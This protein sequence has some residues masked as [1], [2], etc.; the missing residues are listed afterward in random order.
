[1]TLNGTVSIITPERTLLTVETELIERF[2]SFYPCRLKQGAF[3]KGGALLLGWYGGQACD[4]TGRVFIPS[5]FSEVITRPDPSLPSVDLTEPFLSVQD[6]ISGELWYFCWTGTSWEGRTEA[7]TRCTVPVWAIQLQP[8]GDMV[9][10]QTKD[11]NCLVTFDG[12][13]V[14]RRPVDQGD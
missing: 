6:E 10:V 13:I 5:D 7:G 12:E 3:L 2:W 8:M 11:A 14:F 1:M 4:G 9:F